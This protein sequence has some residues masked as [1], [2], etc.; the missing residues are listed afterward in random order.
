[1][2]TKTARAM[3]VMLVVLWAASS[4]ALADDGFDSP[5]AS[6]VRTATEAYRLAL[7]AVHEGYVQTTGYI[8]GF[9][10]MY[11]NHDR[12]DP[13]SLGQPTMLVYDEAGRLVACGY[14]FARPAPY[15]APFDG[16]PASGWYSIPRHIH[17]NVLVGGVMHYGQAPWD[18]NDPP[19]LA[20]LLARNYVPKDGT[21]VFA[22]IHPAVRAVLIWAWRANDAGLYAGENPALP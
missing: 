5:I 7:W 17:Y 2:M 3:I 11:T 1:M 8:D 15:P 12:F 6:A 16:I 9:G 4:K 20:N 21:L 14:Q 13:S 22:M 19:T 10:T 18:S